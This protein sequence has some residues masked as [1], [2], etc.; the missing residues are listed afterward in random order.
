MGCLLLLGCGDSAVKYAQNLKQD[1][2]VARAAEKKAD[3]AITGV[4]IRTYQ[5][6]HGGANPPTLQALVDDG[7]LNKVPAGLEYDPATGQ[8]K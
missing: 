7:L 5:S 6:T 4:A 1:T 8:V 2:D 3:V